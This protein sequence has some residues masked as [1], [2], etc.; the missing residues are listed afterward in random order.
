MHVE[1]L[2]GKMREVERQAAESIRLDPAYAPAHLE[3]G[4]AYEMERN[5]SK[6]VDA[7]DAYVLLALNFADTDSV[8]VQSERLR[9]DSITAYAFGETANLT[10]LLRGCQKAGAT[11]RAQ[12]F[13]M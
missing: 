1:L 4:Q 7:Y 9:G 2:L 3:L 8:R 13:Q 6:A 10:V 5:I 12:T 11:G